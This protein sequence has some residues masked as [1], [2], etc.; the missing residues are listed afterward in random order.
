MAVSVVLVSRSDSTLRGY[1]PLETDILAELGQA[2]EQAYD[3]VVVVPAYIDAGR[4]TVDD[5]H[6]ARDGD[7]FVPVGDTDYAGDATFGYAS[8]N[9]REW[10]A[11]KTEGRVAADEVVSVTLTDIRLGGPDRVRDVLLSCR[12]G[13]PVVVNA[14]DAADL[15]VFVL[16]LV[17]AETS[18]WRALYRTGPSFVPARA[19]R[20]PRP[21][22]AHGDI[23]PDGLRQGHGLVI[24]GSHVELTTRQIGRLRQLPDL[25]FVELD[26]PALL[27]PARGEAEQQRCA[28]ALI[29]SL[30]ERDTV[31]LTSRQRVDGPTGDASLDIART[32]SRALVALTARAVREVPLAWVVGK[33]GITSSDVATDGLSVRRATVLGQLFPGIVSAWRHEGGDDD[34]LVGLP[35]V[36]FAG[37]VGD[38]ST[39]A[40]AVSLL[41]GNGGA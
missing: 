18:G 29:E 40:K 23:F 11:E 35:Y 21:P 41:R 37:N 20:T 26:V 36:V 10:V 25:G 16:G 14:A 6:Y 9:L 13:A 34:S 32:V 30:A 17:A 31:L 39:L 1:F 2:G 7:M 12:G 19:G 22:L 38:Q 8:S 4:V 33:G 15:D 3:A 27:D 5:V 24:V 28:T